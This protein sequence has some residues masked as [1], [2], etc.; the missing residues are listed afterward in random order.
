MLRP[1]H[2]LA[3]LLACLVPCS[4]TFAQAHKASVGI[5]DFEN[6]KSSQSL[7]GQDGWR[8][9]TDT[10]DSQ[11]TINS[12]TLLHALRV[13]QFARGRGLTARVNDT[14]FGF[15]PH[16]AQNHR[17][18]MEF[19]VHPGGGDA[20]FSLGKDLS[21]SSYDRVGPQFGF[22][23]KFL[24]RGASFGALYLADLQTGDSLD[25]WYRLRLEMDFSA[26]DGDGAG[27]LYA[28]NL[29][30]G[31]RAFRARAVLSNV[32]LQLTKMPAESR[33]PATWN[34][35]F[36]RG[37]DANFQADNLIPNAPPI[38]AA[39]AKPAG[40]VFAPLQNVGQGVVL[41]QD[42]KAKYTVG[43]GA[44]SN[45]VVRKAA[46]DLA[47]KLSEI[48]GAQFSVVESDGT[49][50]VTVG[51]PDDLPAFKPYARQFSN[52]LADREAYL[53]KSHA[54]GLQLI[55]KTPIAARDA[56][57]DVLH[58]LGYRQFFPGHVWEVVPRRS[59]LALAVNEKQNPDFISR[60]IWWRSD[61][62]PNDEALQYDWAEKN[63]LNHSGTDGATFRGGGGHV[64]ETIV[65]AKRDEFIAHP[66]YLASI[67]GKRQVP[68]AS[69]VKFDFANGGVREL[70][71][72]YWI[73]YLEKHPEVETISMTPSDGGGWDDSP[74]ASKL[75]SVTDQV[76]G[77]ANEVAETIN[78]HFKRPIYV[79]LY[80]YSDY[81]APP[82][83]KLNP[84]LIV[85][86][87]QG[88]NNTSYTRDE[89]WELW[90][91]QGIK[92]GGT[93]EYLDVF[94]WSFNLPGNTH[95]SDYEY[96]VESIRQAKERDIKI[97]SAESSKSFGANGPGYYIAAQL[98]WK[99]G[100]MNEVKALREDFLTKAFGTA[101]E[102]MRRFYD[103]LDNRRF[104][105]FSLDQVGLLYGDLKD[106]MAKSDDPKVRARL[107]DL[108]NY[109]RYIELS[110]PF[111][112]GGKL[113]PQEQVDA[114]FKVLTLAERMG[115]SP[116][117]T[118]RPAWSIFY[119]GVVHSHPELLPPETAFSVP[120]P[121][122]PLRSRE[123]FSPDEMRRALD[124]GVR[125]YPPQN[126]TTVDYSRNLVPATPLKL[127][128]KPRLSADA[129]T[130]ENRT[131][132][133]LVPVGKTDAR[134]RVKAAPNPITNGEP[135]VEWFSNSQ[136]ERSAK[137]IF[138]SRVSADEAWHEVRLVAPKPGLYRL[139][140]SPGATSFSV[141]WDADQV[142]SEWWEGQSTP[143]P[144]GGMS[145]YFYVPKGTRE[146]TGF[147]GRSSIGEV[148]DASDNVVYN[149]EGGLAGFFRI[150]VEAGQDGKLWQL[151]NSMFPRIMISVPSAF[152]RSPQELLLPAEVVKKDAPTK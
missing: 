67:G 43:V 134:I 83:I 127:A 92:T 145:R 135:R 13:S 5:Y 40:G 20:M 72:R 94:E 124:E 37:G 107:D 84:M 138:S 7:A 33:D 80:I 59:R 109:V 75:G 86:Q 119:G 143:K 52:N 2:L 102:P 93:Y 97:Y 111:L 26:N 85:N 76:V 53:L 99:N 149:F 19:D 24:I 104:P 87:A 130:I 63:R 25:N 139:Q 88:F 129:Y 49:S 132:Y 144:V 61:S 62:H 48:S 3:V 128:D 18:A 22:L 105:E 150:P 133:V 54:R 14:S 100:G 32:N 65:A 113:S 96:L 123:P 60:N 142:V 131:F 41:A 115:D 141:D 106:A 4:A 9:F 70:V 73:E 64:Y 29:S 68:D 31:E 10:P 11:Q 152:A 56:V 66:E 121:Q 146:V 110:I 74:G 55:G 101:K 21:A 30:R 8:E 36:L 82:T 120:A 136:A 77:L 89:L 1:S 16:S 125:K 69:D 34:S 39:T 91:K 50:G 81:S 90:R 151:R 103:V 35:L 51:T 114:A 95:I 15:A 12:A 122:N 137:P 140:I 6:L 23:G 71:K 42:G 28:M 148:L 126:F 58:R 57:W 46:L 147:A 116:M 38:A 117:M 118:L 78:A 108:T 112:Y 98:L 17:A 27:T 44:G 47:S 79:D 45:H